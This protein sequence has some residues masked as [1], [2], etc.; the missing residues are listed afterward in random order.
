M[1]KY[2][3]KKIFYTMFIY[4]LVIVSIFFA[5][6][7]FSDPVQALLGQDST[8]EEKAKLTQELGLDK[9]ANKQFW[10][11]LTGIIFKF[12]FGKSYSQR[13]RKAINLFMAPFAITLT[14]SI[15]SIFIAS[16]LGILTGMFAAYYQNSKKDYFV[17]LLSILI[18]STPSFI[19]GFFLQYFLG[20]RWMLFPISGLESP[21]S[22]ILPISTLV[23]G[24]TFL[25]ARTARNNII[26]ILEQPYIVAARAKGLTPTY[27]LFHHVLKNALMPIIAQIG[28]LFSFMLG[29]SLIVES[30]FNI[31]GVGS[32]IMTSFT[33][34]D[35]P[36]IRASI[37]LLALFISVFNIALELLY[38]CLDPKTKEKNRKF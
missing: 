31:D 1:A 37:I 22:W 16:F 35:I 13:D 18:I 27:I 23:L 10:D 33:K 28:L 34:R 14:L 5:L 12:D 25:I 29:G 24:Q 32:L 11:Y 36:V 20:F 7:L 15:I 26:E 19:I 8:Y 38:V 17:L 4:L 2:T 21:S 6:K 30:I 9:S 3:L